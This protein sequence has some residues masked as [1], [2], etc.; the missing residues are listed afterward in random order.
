M[1]IRK[2]AVLVTVFNRIEMT[3]KCLECFN[4]ATLKTPEIN[5]EVY[6]L[7]DA[8][9]DGTNDKISE[10]F[11]K[12]NLVKGDGSLYWCRGMV[13]SWEAAAKYDYDAY[14]LLNNDSYVFQ[15][16][17]K[18]LLNNALENNYQSIISGAFRSE[19]TNVSTYGGRL[20]EDPI[21]LIPN[22][23]LQSIELLNGNFVLVP[24]VI[25]NSVGMLDP[26]FHHAIGDYDYGLRAIK[27]GFKIFLTDQY[28]GICESHDKIQ[29][30]YDIDVPLFERFKIF[31]SPLGDNPFQRYYFLKRHYS[32]FTAIKAFLITHMYV[33]FP[34]FLKWY[35]T[36][37]EAK[38][39]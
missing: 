1:E 13:R 35:E 31:Y 19:V 12:I 5:Y 14:I 32:L 3:I 30:C 28:V 6:L 7:D 15:D 29:G 36:K 24:K 18:T 2:I 25:Y 23:N 37:K 20:K 33:V 4:E 38:S 16:A 9:T 34:S 21:H 17:L 27:K 8:S 26:L 39:I 11:P 22:G 10:L